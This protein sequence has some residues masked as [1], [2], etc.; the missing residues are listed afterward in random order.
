MKT[1]ADLTLEEYN[2]TVFYCAD[3][4]SLCVMVNEALADEDWDGSYCGVCGS[5]NIKEERFGDWLRED[6]RRKRKRRE[7]EWSK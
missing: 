2:E 6:E 1:S 4:H 7:I 5:L 3:C